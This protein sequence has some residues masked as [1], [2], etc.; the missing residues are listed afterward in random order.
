M[1]VNDTSLLLNA[2]FVPAPGG[3]F[4]AY[5]DFTHINGTAAPGLARLGTHGKLDP[6][7]AADLAADERV[8][9]IA[10]LPDGRSIALIGP[11]ATVA[12][13][14]TTPVPGVPVTPVDPSVGV[15]AGGSAGGGTG[16]VIAPISSATKLIRLRADGRK[17]TTFT[18]LASDGNLRLTS[19]ADGRVLVWGNFRSFGGT[20]RNG[21]ARLNSDG[22][23]DSAF[24]PSLTTATLN[25]AAVTSATDGSAVLSA[26]AY[27]GRN[28]ALYLFRHLLV[29]G[30]VDSRFAP[31]NPNTTFSLLAMQ[32]DGSV[33]AGNTTFSFATPVAVGAPDIPIGVGASGSFVRYLPTGVLDR[34]YSPQIPGLKSIS[35]LTPLS[36][37]RLAVEATVGP[38]SV[39]YGGP[40]VFTLGVNGQLVQ[41]WR[42]VPGARE[43]QRLLA[44]QSDGRLLV[45]Q[46]TLI[47]ASSFYPVPYD[48]TAPAVATI[49]PIFLGPTLVDPALAIS[50]PDASAAPTTPLTAL[51]T[52]IVH[53]YAGNVSQ[54]ETDSAGRVLA[55]GSFTQVDN[56][57][58]AGLARFLAS[59]ALDA[60]FAPAAGELLFAPPD[61]RAIVRRTTIGPVD[62]TDGFHRYV[63][64]IVRLQNDG[65]VDATFAF[66]SNLDATKTNWLL[67][68]P[69]GRLLIAAFDP[70]D[71]KE[72]NLKL[73]WLGADG[74]RLTTLPTV[75]AGFTRF[76]VMPLDATGIAVPTDLVPTIFPI[77]YG[78]PNVLDSA[79]LL[80]SGRLLVA[81]AFSRVNATAR[82]ALARINADGSL[83]A[84]YAPDTTALNFFNSA[85]PLADGRALAFGSSLMSGRWQ[86]R[87]V[88]FRADGTLDSTFQPPADTI[89]NGARALADG[90]FF[91][92]G[93]RFTADGWPDL[94]FAPQLRSSTYAGYAYAAVLTAD[95][96]LWLGGGF[97]QVNGQPRT[98]LARFAPIE[99]VGI[100]VSPTSQKVVAGRDAFFQVAIGTT[101]PATFRWTH[102]GATIA[103]AT[104]AN[105]RLPAVRPADA[106]VY[107]AIVTIG[108]QTFTSDPATLTIVP[109]TS[110]LTNF[111]AR[112]VVAPGAPP[113]IAGVVTA[114]AP[115]R[116]VLLRAVGRGL[117]PMLGFGTVALP[118]PVL[119]FYSGSVMIAQDRGGAVAPAVTSLAS[120]VGAFP[121]NASPVN[122]PGATLGSALMPTLAAGNYT[123][124]TSSGDSG[125]GVSLFEFY[126]T[127]TDGAPALVRNLAIRGTTA[128]GASVLT[129]GSVIAGNGPLHL[130]V[131]GAGPALATNAG[132]ANDADLADAARR[133]GAF[134]L[135]TG[136]RD[137]TV[138]LTLEPG[139]YTAQLPSTAG[140]TG[141]AL[142]EI[143]IVDN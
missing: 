95:G 94:N 21:L 40:A 77:G 136:S 106:G 107:R 138:L 101:Q 45:A 32:P 110:R 108:A 119:T 14:T 67:A 18:P 41:D 104:P 35:R 49:M 72:E 9:G 7:F 140:A 4:L 37:G 2:S 111:S 130:L 118:V 113:Q 66:P 70:D 71:T 128:P 103:G 98:A 127:A 25:I 120:S 27:D 16:V 10:P 115:P 17:D 56:Q 116:T 112:S 54:L 139:A 86:P 125:A 78:R 124:I 52:T 129:A 39:F 43:G 97:D 74:R 8:L 57:P 65:T 99:I 102:D 59:G 143:Y 47:V 122:P 134:A 92:N 131:R 11:G 85:L 100:T 12:V 48:A 109:S 87:V 15:T 105:L 42:K 76:V 55:A 64:Q 93:R 3:Q 84:T 123:A 6:T 79:Q 80:A 26:V 63:T 38:A 44:A 141:T 30:S 137:A 50:P 31:A 135:P 132:W 36:G 73:I 46:G 69:D 58:R 34:N 89:G 114:G 68:A 28:P 83:D 33:L 29:D 126:D 5:G 96:R 91:S 62:A 75:F 22:T 90:S 1:F 60:A 117:T 20:A 88:R 23:L 61:G 121:L 24:A 142:I 81:G 53:R 51:P 19:L 13:V 133:A 82:P